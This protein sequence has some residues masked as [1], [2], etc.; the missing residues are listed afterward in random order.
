LAKIF[1]PKCLCAKLERRSQPAFDYSQKILASGKVSKKRI[2]LGEIAD[3][4]PEWIQCNGCESEFDYYFD[5]K[6]RV[7]IG[8]ER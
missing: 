5:G 4:A 1:C 8:E 6:D 2:R 7:V 3:S